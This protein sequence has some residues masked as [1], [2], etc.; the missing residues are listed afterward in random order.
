M[1]GDKKR[2]PAIEFGV[3]IEDILKN[4]GLADTVDKVLNLIQQGKLEVRI[5]LGKQ[6]KGK[7]PA[8]VTVRL[9]KSEQ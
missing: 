9:K 5:E 1:G 4:V 7:L 8:K 3:K 2:K 6:K